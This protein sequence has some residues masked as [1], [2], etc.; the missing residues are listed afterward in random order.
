[1]LKFFKRHTKYL[2]QYVD[3]WKKQLKNSYF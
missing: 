2:K 1:L 3:D